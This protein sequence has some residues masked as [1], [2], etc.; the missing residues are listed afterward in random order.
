MATNSALNEPKCKLNSFLFQLFTK[1]FSFRRH[2]TRLFHLGL[3]LGERTAEDTWK[4]IGGFGNIL[5]LHH[6]LFD[7]IDILEI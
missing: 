1:D 6:S 2:I 5:L 3:S 4:H 7:G